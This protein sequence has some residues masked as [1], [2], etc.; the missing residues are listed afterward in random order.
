MVVVGSAVVVASVVSTGSSP[1]LVVVARVVLV[2]KSLSLA[3]VVKAVERAEP[4]VVGCSTLLEAVSLLLVAKVDSIGVPDKD[5]VK[6]DSSM[7][8]VTEPV[9]TLVSVVVVPTAPEVEEGRH[10]PA[11]AK[12]LRAA[13]ITNERTKWRAISAMI[14]IFR[15]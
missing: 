9:A 10:G 6:L 2:D 1:V 11:L 7:L 12:G 5:S 13:A 15:F 14:V 3:V 4:V 8:V